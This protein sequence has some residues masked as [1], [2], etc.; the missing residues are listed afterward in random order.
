[1]A[2]ALCPSFL[3]RTMLLSSAPRKQRDIRDGSDLQH[4]AQGPGLQ[5]F[6]LEEAIPGSAHL[7]QAQQGLHGASFS[8]SGRTNLLFSPLNISRSTTGVSLPLTGPL[9]HHSLGAWGQPPR[10]VGRTQSRPSM[11]HLNTTPPCLRLLVPLP[12]CPRCCRV[13]A[14]ASLPGGSTHGL[15]ASSCC[16]GRGQ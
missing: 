2:S 11:S 3:L 4:K 15:S 14:T 13:V 12:Q 7:V 8:S 6:I 1:M 9:L 10:Q 16:R 5:C